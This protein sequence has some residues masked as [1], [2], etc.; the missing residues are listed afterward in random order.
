MQPCV[1]V[2]RDGVINQNPPS[3]VKSW[4]EFLFL[5]DVL[6]ALA[7][8][9]QTTWPVVI[10]TN[11]SV[12]GRGI[13][14]RETLDSIHERMIAEIANA[15]G[16]VNGIYVCPHH[17]DEGCDCRKPQP[18]LICNAAADLQLDLSKSV[19]IGDSWSDMVA[20]IDAGVQPVL[21]K[22]QNS[23]PKFEDIGQ[24]PPNVPIPMVKDLMD[25]AR[26][27][28]SAAESGGHP[29]DMIYY[30]PGK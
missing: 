24:D 25:A 14:T 21:L 6:P 29:A 23:D 9:A 27:L 4:E 12:V 10:I 18:T 3:Y 13:I 22:N 26:G 28:L 5:P 16:R 15:G 17:P 8:I 30:L 1:F 11:Q 2:D 20:A 19:F 7:L